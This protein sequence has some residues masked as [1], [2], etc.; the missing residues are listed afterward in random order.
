MWETRVWTD[1]KERRHRFHHSVQRDVARLYVP[2]GPRWRLERAH[3]DA[4]TLQLCE[5]PGCSDIDS[6]TKE[7]VRDDWRAARSKLR[8]RLLL[9]HLDHDHPFVRDPTAAE[10]VAKTNIENACE[11]C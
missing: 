6:K 7:M 2:A 9:L 3:V 11:T 4:Q 10:T 5:E 1:V 8:N